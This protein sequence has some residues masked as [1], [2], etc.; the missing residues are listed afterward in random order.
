MKNQTICTRLKEKTENCEETSEC[1]PGLECIVNKTSIGD[2]SQCTKP[3]KGFGDWCSDI[4]GFHDCKP[5]FVCED[6][7]GSGQRKCV[8]KV[9][10]EF[11]SCRDQ[12]ISCHHELMRGNNE[13]VTDI[14]NTELCADGL[15]CIYNDGKD[16]NCS[17]NYK[18]GNCLREGRIP[19]I[20]LKIC[21]TR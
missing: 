1:K 2:V 9:K 17:N 18:I 14:P 3:K 4:D 10:R 11:E 15:E 5:Q 16:G 7:K 21:K 19:L 12:N 20:H 8:F 13:N 6:Y